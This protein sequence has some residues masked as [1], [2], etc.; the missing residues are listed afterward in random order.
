MSS[1]GG[2]VTA[3]GGVDEGS[4]MA[5]GSAMPVGDEVREDH[6]GPGIQESGEWQG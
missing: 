6:T 3:G 5:D 4:A 2:R 1:V